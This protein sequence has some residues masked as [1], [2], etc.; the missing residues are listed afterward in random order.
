MVGWF[1]WLDTPPPLAVHLA[2]GAALLVLVVAALSR[3]RARSSVVV[4]LLVVGV[5]AVPVVLEARSISDVGYFWQGRYTLPLALG[6]PLVAAAG[7]RLRPHRAAV[8]LLLAVLVVCHLV[9]FVITLGRY[10]VGMGNGLGLLDGRWAPPLPPLVLVGAFA[11][12][13]LV[14]AVGLLRLARSHAEPAAQA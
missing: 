14:G 9:G 11:V 8:A 10:T 3:S 12:T 4:L 2:W 7:S 6:V 5:L 13:L 1:G